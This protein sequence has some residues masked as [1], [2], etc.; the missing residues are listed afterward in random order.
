MDS[1]PMQNHLSCVPVPT[2]TCTDHQPQSNGAVRNFDPNALDSFPPGYRFQPTDQE[3]IV[4]YLAKKVHN[5]ALPANK[6][7]EVN[8]YLYHPEELAGLCG[9]SREHCMYFFTP[10]DRKYKNGNRPNRVAGGGYWKA[11][12]GDQEIKFGGHLVGAK[13]ALVFYNG[14]PSEG[15]KTNW[16]M[17]EFVVLENL[18]QSQERGA[19]SI[20]LDDWVLCRIYKR[21]SRK[22]E[23][24]RTQDQN[25][26]VQRQVIQSDVQA[27]HPVPW[28]TPVSDSAMLSG[29]DGL[30]YNEN[31]HLGVDRFSDGNGDFGFVEHMKQILGDA[32]SQS[33]IDFAYPDPLIKDGSTSNF[34]REQQQE[35]CAVPTLDDDEDKPD[36]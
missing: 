9:S 16:I 36:Q 34:Q 10:R 7:H 28:R 3:L 32:P 29:E 24:E 12:S 26:Q 23:R 19:K 20:K 8:L 25:D 2:Q 35:V 31:E 14:N 5:R 15:S 6:I 11:T 1:H 21:A 27:P 13:K 18:P 4:C 17:H 33:S 30:P 22:L